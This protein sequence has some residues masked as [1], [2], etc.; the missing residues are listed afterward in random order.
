MITVEL[1]ERERN[2][3]HDALVHLTA[4]T[5]R[6]LSEHLG[7]TSRDVVAFSNAIAKTDKRS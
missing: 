2:V 6:E 5:R 4:F 7:W 3:I 1:T